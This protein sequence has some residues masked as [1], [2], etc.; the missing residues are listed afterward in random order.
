MA[1]QPQVRWFNSQN[2]AQ[3]DNWNIGTVDAGS[4]SP[5]TT[6]LIWN[7]RGGTT[8][9]S[10]MKNVTITTKDS[11]GDNT[12]ELVTDKWIKVKVAT[13]SETSFT[14]IGGETT[15]S[16]KAG[17]TTAAG[18]ISGAINDGTTTN[19]LNNFAKVTLIA[20]PSATA[21]AGNVDF[22]LRVAYQYS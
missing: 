2:T 5:E 18:T 13:M 8:V 10:D 14:P 6:L 17:G 9:A 16:I 12:G 19:A 3:V 21:T 4:T 1:N 15:K 20:E 7:N 11:K 22:L